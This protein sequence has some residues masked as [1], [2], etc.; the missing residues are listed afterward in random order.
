MVEKTVKVGVRDLS[1]AQLDSKDKVKGEITALPGLISAKMNV[2]VNQE[3]FFADD[4]VYA[5][6]DSGISELGLELNVA[7]INTE[8]KAQLL[9]VKVED[10]MEVYDGD[11]EI[12]AVAMTFRSTTNKNKAVWFGFAKGKFTLP[13]HDLNT[14]EASASA[15]TDTISGAFEMRNDRVMYVIAREDSKDFDLKKFQAKIFGMAVKPEPET[16]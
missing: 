3:P 13:S 1:F 10:G 7:D 16:K 5:N 2:T 15:Q 14:K 12:P 8:I 11:M 9:G 4:G 6:L